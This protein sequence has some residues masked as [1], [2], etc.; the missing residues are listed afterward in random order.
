MLYVLLY[1]VSLVM[2]RLRQLAMTLLLALWVV[3]RLDNEPSVTT[4]TT[5]MTQCLVLRR[6]WLAAQLDLV[7]WNHRA[8]PRRHHR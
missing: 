3:L 6:G 5:L 4:L 1:V 7:V 2:K 8:V